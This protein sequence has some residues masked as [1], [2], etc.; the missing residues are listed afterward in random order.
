MTEGDTSA[1]G[2]LSTSNALETERP[3]RLCLDKAIVSQ[4]LG[5]QNFSYFIN[6]IEL[7]GGYPEFRLSFNPQPLHAA[8]VVLA[9]SPLP[10]RSRTTVLYWPPRLDGLIRAQKETIGLATPISACGLGA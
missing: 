10:R 8:P 9:N 2:H 3:K 5:L 1:Q 4:V 6:F 7:I